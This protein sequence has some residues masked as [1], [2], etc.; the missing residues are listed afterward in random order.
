MNR[1]HSFTVTTYFDVIGAFL[2]SGISVNGALH[3]PGHGF[4]LKEHTKL[5]LQCTLIGCVKKCI[6]VNVW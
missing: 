2:L 6:I 5:Y 3:Q 1:T 4:D